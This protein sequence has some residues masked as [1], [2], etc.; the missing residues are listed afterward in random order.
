MLVFFSTLYCWAF[1]FADF[2][3][4]GIIYLKDVK[5]M[6]WI[7]YPDYSTNVTDRTVKNR[8]VPKI[9]SLCQ[10]A[11]QHF[12]SYKPVIYYIIIFISFIR[13]PGLS[14]LS[15]SLKGAFKWQIPEFETRIII[16][17]I[18]FDD[19]QSSRSLLVWIDIV[20][21]CQSY[22]NVGVS[23]KETV[24]TRLGVVQLVY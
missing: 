21:R 24:L 8:D 7:G 2:I 5:K 1:V 6:S 10:V 13:F 12:S 22:L 3:F 19:E 17:L 9:N 15:G 16:T 14:G 23:W 18:S 4:L 11:Y 20:V